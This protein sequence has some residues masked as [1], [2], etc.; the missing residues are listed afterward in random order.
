MA[1]IARHHHLNSDFNDARKDIFV[2]IRVLA[3]DQP[4]DSD[5]PACG[6]GMKIVQACLFIRSGGCDLR[7]G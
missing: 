3:N 2:R 7:E 4:G 5:F 6:A 1:Q